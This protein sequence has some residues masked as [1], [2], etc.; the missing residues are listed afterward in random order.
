[1]TSS[2][3]L[4]RSHPKGEAAAGSKRKVVGSSGLFLGR[5]HRPVAALLALA[6]VAAMAI[7]GT[8]GASEAKAYSLLGCK[9]DHSTITWNWAEPN[10]RQWYQ[11][12][13]VAA[14]NRWGN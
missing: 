4:G 6:F 14:A 3:L 2:V 7:S 13:W 9:F 5:R 11:P 1:M 12:R 10:A 8:V